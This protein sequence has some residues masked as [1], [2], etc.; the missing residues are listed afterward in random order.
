MGAA[1]EMERKLLSSGHAPDRSG[2]AKRCIV[3]RRPK[4]S[5]VG[6]ARRLLGCGRCVNAWR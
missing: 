2:R 5:V 1:A 4:L 6:T 3:G